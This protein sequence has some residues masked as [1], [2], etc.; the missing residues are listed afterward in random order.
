MKFKLSKKQKTKLKE[1]WEETKSAG[2]ATGKAILKYSKPASKGFETSAMMIQDAF[3]ARVEPRPMP[4]N[5]RRYKYL[6]TRIP[7]RKRVNPFEMV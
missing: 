2:K 6:N 4:Q 5:L 1:F 7:L 3:N